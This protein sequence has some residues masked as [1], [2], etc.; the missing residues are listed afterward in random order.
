LIDKK[1][2]PLKTKQQPLFI[3][4]FSPAMRRPVVV[5]SSRD[6]TFIE[7]DESQLEYASFRTN[8]TRKGRYTHVQALGLTFVL[9]VVIG[10]SSMVSTHYKSV[11]LNETVS[12]RND[13]IGMTTQQQQQ[14]VRP[15]SNATIVTAYFSLASKFPKE[16]YNK[17]MANML[18]LQDSMVIYTSHDLVAHME[19]HRSHARDRTVVIG[20]DM[21]D[22]PLAKEYSAQ[23]WEGQLQQ[24]PERQIHRSYQLF[25]IWLS[26]SWFVTDAIKKD[27]F[28]SHV[29]IWSDI[30]CF[31]NDK[32]NGKTMMVHYE[33]VP[34]TTTLQMA[35]HETKVPRYIWWNNKYSQKENFYHSGSQMAAYRDTW[36]QWHQ[37]Y[38][39]TI[40]GFLERNMFI[41]EDQTVAQSTCLRVPKLCSY[42]PTAQVGDNHYFGLRFVLHYGGNYTYWKSPGNMLPDPADGQEREMYQV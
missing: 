5:V 41:G 11:T 10:T 12:N 38:I 6:E 3:I 23:F 8:H 22:L 30:G 17:W 40:K 20:M 18:S 24:D 28:Q 42:V 9:F 4:S 26:K 27:Y 7:D 29:Y 21:T 39:A 14:L 19:T 35:H 33:V 13:P 16:H 37:E 34:E 32:Y 36:K 31:R 15:Q 25:W 1:S 2:P